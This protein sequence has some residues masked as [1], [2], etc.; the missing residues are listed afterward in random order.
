MI[1]G[2]VVKPEVMTM[3]DVAAELQALADKFWDV[4]CPSVCGDC[5]LRKMNYSPRHNVTVDA[6]DF[7]S[8]I[9]QAK[10]NRVVE[11]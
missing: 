8:E 9:R 3:D 1:N 7:L 11:E 2:E 10:A 5:P 4:Q 6:C